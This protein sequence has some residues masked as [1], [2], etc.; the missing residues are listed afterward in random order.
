MRGL[1]YLVSNSAI[2]LGYRCT[3]LNR[4]WY[5]RKLEIR[6]IGDWDQA[7]IKQ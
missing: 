4:S 6:L 2:E 5:Y 7:D 3:Y 1:K